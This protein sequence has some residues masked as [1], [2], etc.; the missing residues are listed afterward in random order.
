MADS[1]N[2]QPA[3]QEIPADGPWNW[4]W[5]KVAQAAGNVTDAVLQA[6][7]QA[8]ESILPKMP[9]EMDPSELAA[10]TNNK[11]VISA[12]QELPVQQQP[13]TSGGL[14]AKLVNT[15]SGGKHLDPNGNLL[16]SS[17]GAKGITQVMPK[18]GGDPGYGVTPLQ[19]QSVGEYLRFGHDYLNAMM[20]H[21]GNQEQALAAYNAGPGRVEDAI[22]K[23]ISKGGDWKQY[24]PQ[25][26]R[27]YVRK[28]LG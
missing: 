15:E 26:T 12:T 8:T 2:T 4:S 23:S 27:N 13:L 19:D 9:W 1:N 17:A 24:L 28:I 14:F 21:F 3:T 18:T 6:G 10:Q 22:Q 16:T 11:R 5:D 20:K 25:E 7:K